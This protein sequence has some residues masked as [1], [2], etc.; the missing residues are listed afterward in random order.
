[1]KKMSPLQIDQ[2][3]IF[4]YWIVEQRRETIEQFYI[5]SNENFLEHELLKERLPDKVVFRA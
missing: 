4:F 5:R 3:D 2:L 1:M